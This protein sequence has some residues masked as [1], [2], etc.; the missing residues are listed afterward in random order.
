MRF[1]VNLKNVFLASFN[2][3]SIIFLNIQANIPIKADNKITN[4]LASISD[5]KFSIAICNHH[6]DFSEKNILVSFSLF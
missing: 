4:I 2:G 3:N 5:I 6:Q 1:S